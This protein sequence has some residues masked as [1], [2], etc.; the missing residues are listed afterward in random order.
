MRPSWTKPTTLIK[1]TLIYT[2]ICLLIL[3]IVCFNVHYI[4]PGIRES[5]ACNTCIHDGGF[6][7]IHLTLY[8]IIILQAMILLLFILFRTVHYWD[9]IISFFQKFGKRID[10]E[11]EQSN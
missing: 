6:C 10:S 9:D 2:S 1:Y 11:W 5:D 7:S 4:F 3:G 8:K